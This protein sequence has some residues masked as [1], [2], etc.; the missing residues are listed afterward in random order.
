[1]S[2]YWQNKTCLVTGASSG[3][4]LAIARSLATHGAT[5]LLNARTK[6]PLEQAV[7]ILAATGS[8]AIA[9][10]GDVT[11]QSDVEALASEVQE[12]FGGL[13]LLCNCAGRSA[14]GEAID[15]TP[16]NFQDL[17]EINFLSV[18][19]MTRSFAPSADRRRWAFGEYWLT[20]R[21][22]GT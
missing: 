18:V 7:E 20:G 16:E 9:L 22:G 1:M 17:W 4:G 10:P 13:D 21:Q 19:R 2:N 8:N 6:A 15:T 12:R 3:L 11:D 14:R 5:V